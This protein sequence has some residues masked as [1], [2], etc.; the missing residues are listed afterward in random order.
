MGYTILGAALA[1]LV[2][3]TSAS[4]Q[5]TGCPAT[6]TWRSY[7]IFPSVARMGP[8][9][10]GTFEFCFW[11]S[12]GSPLCTTAQRAGA[13]I[14]W[15]FPGTM[16]DCDTIQMS[17]LSFARIRNGY[18][19]D[20]V[21]D[22]SE[23]CDDGNF[24]GGDGCEILCHATTCGNG[25]LDP[26]EVCDDGF[27][28]TCNDWCVAQT[29][30][31]GTVEPGED[32][33]DGNVIDGDGCSAGCQ[34][35]RCG[36]GIVQ[37]GEVCDDGNTESGDACSASC[38]PTACGNGVVEPGETCDDSNTVPCDGCSAFCQPETGCGDGS[39]CGAEECDDANNVGDDGCGPTCLIERCGDGTLRPGEQCDDGNT[40]PCDGCSSVCQDETGCGDGSRCGA[41]ACDDGNRVDGDGCDAQCRSEV[42]G[43]GVRRGGEECDDGNVAGCDGCSAVCRIEGGCGD[44]SACGAEACDDGNRDD[45]DG[46]T[47]RC[48]VQICGNGTPEVHEACDDG[49]ETSCDGCSAVCTVETGCGD[50][51]RCGAEESDDGNLVDGD[52]C[53]ASCLV[54]VC[55]NGILEPGEECD[56]GNPWN[57]DGCTMQ[58]RVEVP[59]DD[60]GDGVLEDGDASGVPGD[61]PCTGGNTVGCDD[62]CPWSFDPTQADADGD[63]TG[64]PCDW[65]CHGAF[66][67]AS[68]SGTVY[69]VSVAPENALSHAAVSIWGDSC[70]ESAITDA[71]GAYAFDAFHP[72]TYTVQVHPP[73]GPQQLL[74]VIRSPIPLAAGQALP[75]QDIVLPLRQPRPPGTVVTR[76]FLLTT[77]CPGGAATYVVTDSQ[78]AT[79]ITG[80]MAEHSPGIYAAN[81]NLSGVSGPLGTTM[82]ITC[83]DTTVET[84]VGFDYIDPSGT[85]RFVSGTAA[86]GAVVTLLRSDTPTGPFEVIPNGSVLMSPSNRTNPDVAKSDGHFGW[87]VV[88]GYYRVQA[89]TAACTTESAV[90]TIPPPVTDLA[91]V[92]QCP[93][94]PPVPASACR[95][96]IP[97]ARGAAQLAMKNAPTS[98]GDTITWKWKKGAATPFSDLGDPRSSNDWSLCVY[99]PGGLVFEAEAPAG[100]VCG[101]VPCWKPVQNVGFTYKSKDGAPD[102]LTTLVIKSGAAGKPTATLK[103]KGTNLALPALPL[104]LPLVAQLQSSTGPCL[105][106]TFWTATKND[107]TTL[108]S[109]SE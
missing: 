84:D 28:G 106:A 3:V 109:K 43:D 73:G 25:V 95:M 36:N 49:N 103:G 65:N 58:C 101:T 45:T 63:G 52:G 87:D 99:G 32:C 66:S 13:Q 20:G 29:C 67:T 46:C 9:S 27:G 83:P 98:T 70:W 26:G 62:S 60:D 71:A 77:G 10:D 7:G 93:A 61:A 18:C 4:A 33:D 107:G 21:V 30:G 82:T 80:A 19:G 47:S 42:C 92:L 91:L 8:E 11:L 90:L 40:S 81:V 50:G 56:D 15:L 105:E 108:K 72:G 51:T 96:A 86:A 39:R 48:E 55:G 76:S 53:T 54:Q 2:G 59:G 14:T 41:E 37:A 88:A 57:G 6:G 23:T 69:G 64:D 102:G 94:C 5:F 97:G 104:E 34:I 31:N 78:G 100:G 35:Q 79:L 1:V 17:P 75:G 22:P 38:T 16:T 12:P 85:I 89:T 24:A 44:G 74:S 68:I